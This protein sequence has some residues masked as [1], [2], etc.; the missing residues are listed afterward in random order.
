MNDPNFAVLPGARAVA[1]AFAVNEKWMVSSATAVNMRS[2]PSLKSAALGQKVHG[3]MLT[4]TRRLEAGGGWIQLAERVD[5]AVAWM[6]IADGRR[7]LLTRVAEAAGGEAAAAGA[8]VQSKY[9]L[10]VSAAGCNIR[11]TPSLRARSFGA[12]APVP[13]R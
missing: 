1:S 13:A 2:E 5:G 11:E 8:M 4:A 9:W 10:V 12:Q 6:R 3:D 7:T